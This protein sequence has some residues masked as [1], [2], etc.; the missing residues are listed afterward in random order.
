MNSKPEDR[1]YLLL[2]KQVTELSQYI[3]KLQ[4]ENK[5][6]ELTWK[7]LEREFKSRPRIEAS[8][9]NTTGSSSG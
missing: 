8:K 2:Y 9:G 1:N 4:N 5:N 6:Y 3:H 7:L